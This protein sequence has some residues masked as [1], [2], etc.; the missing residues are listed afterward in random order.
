MNPDHEPAPL[1]EGRWLWRRIYAFAATAGLW[2]LLA[3]VIHFAPSEAL[4]RLADGVMG[5]MALVL[6]LYLVAPTAQQLVELL[7][8]LKL[9]LD[10]GGRS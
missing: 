3:L 8:G 1:S 10:R 9:R 6:V 7:A 2:G 4:P 5:L